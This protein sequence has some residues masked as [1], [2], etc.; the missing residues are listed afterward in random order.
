[1]KVLDLCAGA[2]GMANGFEQVGFDVTGVDI[3]EKAVETF[4]LNNRGPCIKADLLK[5][6]IE[7]D[8]DVIIGGPSCRPWS[9]VNLTRRG[10]KHKDYRL[11]S[12]YFEHIEHNSPKVF[13]MENVPLIA[14]D[15]VLQQR[16]KRLER[17]DYSVIG[18]VVKYS[19]YGAPTKRRRFIICGI[20]NGNAQSFF[21][22]LASYE[23]PSKH[24]ADVI[25]DFRNKKNGE[26]TDHVWPELRTI[27]K[28]R[29]YYKTGKYGWYVLN[30]KEPAPSF[31]NVMK[32]YILHPDAFN[33]K[34]TRVISVKEA[35]LIM[36]FDQAF[37]FPQNFGLGARYQMVV[38]SVSPV[39][40]QIAA[41]V[42]K[43]L[44][45]R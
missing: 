15:A 14:N 10:K 26:V 23:K 39:F 20:K 32:T 6:L 5:E 42:T 34:P 38:D 31:G 3:S 33:G 41:M 1:M 16:I 37:R 7:L 44:L 12:K 29:D 40:S 18:K 8:C 25:W 28:Y 19:D 45:K 2:G 9:A 30:W 17:K 35:M 24:V 43:E 13:L 4:K 27:D 36:G 22:K 11:L 21:D